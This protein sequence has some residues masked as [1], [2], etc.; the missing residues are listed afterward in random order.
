MATKGF[1][2]V[3][4]LVALF[5]F[6]L[7]STPLLYHTVSK[8]KV[9]SGQFL[10][11]T[12]WLSCVSGPHKTAWASLPNFEGFWAREVSPL[13]RTQ[14]LK[15]GKRGCWGYQVKTWMLTPMKPGGYRIG[16]GKLR[17]KIGGKD[18]LLSG[19]YVSIKVLPLPEKVM[20]TG[21]LSL[22]VET[23]PVAGRIELRVRV[24]GDP[25][26]VPYPEISLKKGSLTLAGT[27][28]RMEAESNF[29]GE[30]RFTYMAR[31]RVEGLAFT[32][33]VFDPVSRKV[34][35]ISSPE[36]SLMPRLLSQ[37]ELAY[38]SGGSGRLP[39]SLHPFFWAMAGVLFFLSVLF[40]G[41]SLVKS[42]T[43][44]L[45]ARIK[46]V[47][48]SAGRDPAEE[49]LQRLSSLLEGDLREQVDRLRF[50]PRIDKREFEKLI[51]KVRERFK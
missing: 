5:P 21:P 35:V 14:F 22:K 9:Y 51:S 34:K 29:S 15:I 11:F 45:K 43:P 49:V 30:K 23:D 25:A 16:G 4:G 10:V 1:F 6:F 41:L 31:G 8:T 27:A 36:V 12:S 19:N 17:V 24:K 50:S 40:L 13:R 46:K 39:L 38:S 28:E 20:W 3:K 32:Y 47:L 26:L 37:H 2:P 42:R 48:E 7:L 18:Y 33:R 44:S